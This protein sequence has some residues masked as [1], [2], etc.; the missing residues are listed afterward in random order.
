MSS[1]PLKAENLTPLRRTELIALFGVLTVFTPFAVDMYMPALPTIARD[2]H[3]SI[4]AV[5]HSLTSYF[6]GLAV[7]QAVV[8]PLSDRFGRRL[9]LMLGMGLYVLGSVACAI[10]EGP[11]TLDAARFVQ[12][13]GGCAGT[14]LARACVRDIFPAGEAARIFAQML[15]ILSVSPLFAPLFGGWMLLV[16]DWRAIFWI[17]AVLALLAML[18]VVARLPESHPG[19]DRAL[20]PVEVA[21]D[22]WRIAVDQRF[23]GYVLSAT[24]SGA[25]LYVYLTGWAHVVIDIFGVAPQYFGYTFLLNGIGLIVASQSTARILHHRP[26]PRVLFWALVAQTFGAAMALLFGWMGWGGLFGLLPWLFIYCALVGAVNPTAA[27]LALM[28]FGESAG[29]AS[30]L[31][32]IM[33]YGG[34]TIASMAMGAF[35]PVTPVPLVALMLACGAGA[36]AVDLRYRRVLA[37]QPPPPDLPF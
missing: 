5:E 6:L 2:F 26:A 24:L 1:P 8:G 20:H 28:G 9:P 17:Q 10:T 4:A 3:A 11:L 33:I 21:R 37:S 19:S 27:G 36:L 15:L 32:G 23:L 14:V 25:G 18:A 7:G 13:M 31:M 30:A 12:A 29:M 34:G 22:Y 16:A 35:N